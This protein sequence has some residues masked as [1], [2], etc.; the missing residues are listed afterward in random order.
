MIYEDYFSPD[1]HYEFAPDNVPFFTTRDPWSYTIMLPG[2]QK[3]VEL[4][5]SGVGEFVGAGEYDAIIEPKGYKKATVLRISRTLGK[6]NTIAGM[7]TRW[8]TSHCTILLVCKQIYDEAFRFLYR[9]PLFAFRAATRL[10]NFL[11]VV[12]R[13]NLEAI[14]RLHLYYET[15]GDHRYI[16]RTGRYHSMWLRECKSAS[17]KLKNLEELGVYVCLHARPIRFHLD[18]SWVKPLLQFRRLSCPPKTQRDLGLKGKSDDTLYK[19]KSVKIYIKPTELEHSDDPNY[20]SI[21]KASDDLHEL[22]GQCISKAILGAENSDAMVDLLEIW[23][24]KY[25]NWQAYLKLAE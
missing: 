9:K 25:A 16:P 14:T 3:L 22:F 20:P 19:L 2:K 12:P 13:L 4:L 5:P 23:N 21:V 6:H 10:E 11:A 24:A 1:I 17:W 7:R 18:E 8:E 15:R